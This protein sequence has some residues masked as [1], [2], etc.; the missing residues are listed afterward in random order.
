MTK[1]DKN[2]VCP[3]EL[4]GGLD[5]RFRR[6]FQNPYKILK[7]YVKPGMRVFELGCGPGYFTPGI[8]VLA[9]ESGSVVAADLQ[10]DMLNMLETKIESTPLKNRIIAHK[11]GKDRIGYEGKADFV[12][13][14][15][16][17][18]EISDKERLFKE[19]FEILVPGGTMLIVEPPFHVPGKEFRLM[20]EIINA[21]GFKTKGFPRMF[22][23]KAVLLE[24]PV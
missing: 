17:I 16:V 18:H 11:C 19:L 21:A 13:A 4:A 23:N 12:F 24:R 20:M 8:A 7:P 6:I 1:K 22:P 2:R 5:N 3:A 14:F 10:E 9:G 15:Y